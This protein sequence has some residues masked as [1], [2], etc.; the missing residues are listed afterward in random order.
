MTNRYR[1]EKTPKRGPNAF[2]SEKADLERRHQL[3]TEIKQHHGW[4]HGLAPGTDHDINCLA[5]REEEGK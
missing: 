1:Q 4:A 2:G 5:C 3:V